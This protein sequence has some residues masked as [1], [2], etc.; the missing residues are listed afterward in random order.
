VKHAV[1]VDVAILGSGPCGLGAAW[2]IERLR[3]AGHRISY[4]VIDKEGE[5]GGSASSVTT[6]EGFTFDFGGHILFPHEHY[7]DFSALLAEL[8][9]A[10]HESVPVRGVWIDQRFV[11]YPVQ[12]NIHRLRATKLLPALAGMVRVKARKAFERGAHRDAGVQDAKPSL[13][14]Y[15]VNEFGAGLTKHVLGPLN[16][17]MWAH[18]LMDLSSTW[19]SQRSG[20]SAP[21]VAHVSVR[22]TLRS[23][24]TRRDNLG[25]NA[26][27]R[28]RYP[29]SGGSGSIWKSLAA[30][31]PSNVF[32][33]KHVVGIDTDRRR[34][35]FDDNSHV[36]YRYLLSTMPLDALL[37]LLPP[38]T[39]ITQLERRLRFSRA[40]FTG[41]GFHGAPPPA[42]AG[43]HSFHVPQHDIPCWR[44]TLPAALAPGNVPSSQHWSILCEA[45]VAAAETP[46]VD[47]MSERI[48]SRLRAAGLINAESTVVSRW[49]AKLR[50]GYPTPF[51]GR[52][53]MLQAVDSAL[54][55]RHI[56]SR[57][58]FGGWKYEV[59]NQDHTFMQG[60][61]AID[62]FISGKPERTYHFP[63]AVN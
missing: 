57:G 34:L 12:R 6:P 53:D 40:V 33:Q 44:V 45:S 28:V 27:T 16:A 59:S 42:L 51:L 23:I 25:W 14:S 11:P 58:R 8:V 63:T 20:S 24:V 50:H 56:L 43:V 13:Q 26:A 55:E 52:D 3:S 35:T 15:L 9:P 46:D 7:A 22:Q 49:S 38:T 1:K 2:Q 32:M 61:E 36:S 41:F 21:N 47:R 54:K 30:R 29:A 39:A 48:E 5:P 60:V 62:Y 31:L 4:T 18:P 19:T 10:W 37:A 17:K